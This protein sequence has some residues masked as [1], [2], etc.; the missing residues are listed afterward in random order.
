MRRLGLIQTQ[1]EENI[2]LSSCLALA[3]PRGLK[4]PVPTLLIEVSL[5]RGVG[6][7]VRVQIRQESL[8]VNFRGS[9]SDQDVR[10]RGPG[11][12][13]ESWYNW[14][15]ILCLG[16]GPLPTAGVAGSATLAVCR[17][18]RPRGDQNTCGLSPTSGLRMQRV[19]CFFSS[20][21]KDEIGLVLHEHLLYCSFPF[22]SLLLS[23]GG[24]SLCCVGL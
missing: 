9:Q 1:G 24:R 21:K 17:R 14:E 11:A 16:E 2:C 4:Q 12:E 3:L 8:R 10:E 22:F 6:A 19:F 20:S 23:S 18:A 7:R 13:Q 5:W 15:L